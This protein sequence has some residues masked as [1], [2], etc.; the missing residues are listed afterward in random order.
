MMPRQKILLVDDDTDVV[1]ALNIRLKSFGYDVVVAGDA[2]AAISIAL[3]EKPDLIVLDIGLPG[4]DGF[5]VMKWLGLLSELALT[6]VIVVSARDP[7]I[8]KQKA[9][10]AGASAYFQKPIDTNRFLLAMRGALEQAA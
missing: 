2:M 4:G 9:F 10:D 1:R 6:P 8:A 5:M 3:N 7:T